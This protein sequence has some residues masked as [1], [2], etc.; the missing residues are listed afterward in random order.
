MRSLNGS[1]NHDS[2][3]TAREKVETTGNQVSISKSMEYLHGRNTSSGAQ[4][5][6]THSKPL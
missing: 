5:T 1:P 3:Q 4:Q 6:P 2:S